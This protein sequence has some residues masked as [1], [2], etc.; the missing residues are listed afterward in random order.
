MKKTVPF[1]VFMALTC[2]GIQESNADVITA[3]GTNIA[4]DH[5]VFSGLA[6]TNATDQSGLSAPYTSGVTD[7]ASYTAT[8]THNGGLGQFFGNGPFSAGNLDFDLGSSL[9]I[10]SLALWNAS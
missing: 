5:G 8:T 9:S 7:F 4:N 1:A 10:T 6:V 3:M 2:F